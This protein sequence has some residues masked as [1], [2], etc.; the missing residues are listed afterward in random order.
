MK[1]KTNLATIII[2]KNGMRVEEK[3]KPYDSDDCIISDFLSASINMDS[4]QHSWH[5]DVSK[6]WRK[7][8]KT[9]KEVRNILQEKI[10]SREREIQQLKDA[11]HILGRW[12][13]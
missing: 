5:H 2:D 8:S 11:I 13:Y 6:A 7:G 3:T 10:K 4:W 9:R 1:R 12:H